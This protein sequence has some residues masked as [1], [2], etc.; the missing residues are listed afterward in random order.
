[1]RFF[2]LLKSYVISAI[3]QPSFHPSQNQSYHKTKLKK[4]KNHSKNP[5]AYALKGKEMHLRGIFV[6]HSVFVAA[7]AANAIFHFY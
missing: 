3:V 2:F 7:A 5:N 1:M 4:I 6:H